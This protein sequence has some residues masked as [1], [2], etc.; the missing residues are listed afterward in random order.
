M[1][2]ARCFGILSYKQRTVLKYH[3]ITMIN[4]N[5][6]KR[7]FA[8][9]QFQGK[10]LAT[11]LSDITTNKNYLWTM[12]DSRSYSYNVRNINFKQKC[13]FPR[14]NNNWLESSLLHFNILYIRIEANAIIGNNIRDSRLAG[15]E[16]DYR[17]WK[18]KL[19]LS[20]AH[21]QRRRSSMKMKR[22]HFHS[23][24]GRPGKDIIESEDRYKR[25]LQTQGARKSC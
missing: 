14:N 25:F 19:A 18:W 23:R 11:N 10:A 16:G 9:T 6:C 2:I 20:F 8:C 7:N 12:S 22:I 5:S 21:H 24:E 17:Y 13:N 15:S 3:G 4:Q 1:G